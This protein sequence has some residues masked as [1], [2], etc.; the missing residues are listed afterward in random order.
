MQ[1]VLPETEPVNESTFAGFVPAKYQHEQIR[2]ARLPGWEDLNV[3]ALALDLGICAQHARQVLTKRAAGKMWLY[4][5]IARHLCISVD[6]LLRRINRARKL[7]KRR[8]ES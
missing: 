7:D 8:K 5:S 6:E 3:T 4:E 1:S 2:G